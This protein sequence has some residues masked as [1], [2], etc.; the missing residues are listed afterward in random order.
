MKPLLQVVHISDVH[1]AVGSLAGRLPPIADRLAR[2]AA[3]LP[4]LGPWVRH[5]MD[6]YDP[7][8][9]RPFEDFLRRTTSPTSGWVGPTWLVDTGDL[10][11]F[12][13]E[14]SLVAG[15]RLLHRWGRY[16][17]RTLSIHGNHDAWP[18]DFPLAPKAA[19]ESH[20]ARLRTQHYPQEWPEAPECYDPPNSPVRI[21]LY[22]LN[23]VEHMPRLNA[24]ALGRIKHDRYWETPAGKRIR[25]YSLRRLQSQVPRSNRRALRLL[26]V[27][28]PIARVD[29]L[30]HHR[31]MNGREVA[32]YLTKSSPFH[33]ILG[34]HTHALFPPHG[35]LASSTAALRHTPLGDHQAQLVVGS[36]MQRDFSDPARSSL[37]ADRWAHQLVLLRFYHDEAEQALVV[38][39]LLGGRTP[40]VDPRFE[41]RPVPQGPE[42]GLEALRIPISSL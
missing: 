14:P 7:T 17:S 31:V 33:L 24:L 42:D 19:I 39:R 26:A 18:E 28:H 29:Y 32:R 27:H 1:I 23:S 4:I 41:I 37:V 36:L 34:G 15:R 22:A 16:C 12:G 5:G 35:R 9:I 11:T 3:P 10:T 6:P 8:A 30:P 21:E 20:R 40:G 2:C 13:D 38:A 25:G